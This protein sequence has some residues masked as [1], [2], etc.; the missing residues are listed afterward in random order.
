[1]KDQYVGDIGDY[2]K[3]VLLRALA[4][5][6]SVG[7]NWYLTPPDGKTDGKF[8]EY[9]TRVSDSMD[10][11]L[12]QRLKELLYSADGT[13]LN[14]NRNVAAIESSDI[15]PNALFFNETID[16]SKAID[17]KAYR[18]DWVSRSLDALGQP[19]IIFLDPDNGLEVKSVPPTRK[20][21][22]KF[23]TYDEA[24]RY[25][26]RAKVALV[27]YNHRD[28][29]PNNE[30]I[31][32]FLRFY[33]YEGTRNSFVYRLTFRKV[34]VRD[35][36][37]ITKPEFSKE[38]ADFLHTFVCPTHNKYFTIG[39]LPIPYAN[40]DAIKP[41]GVAGAVFANISSA[42]TLYG[43]DKFAIPK[44]GH[45]FAAERANHLYDVFTGKDAQ[46]VGD[47]NALNGADRMVNEVNIQT[48]FW[49]DG[50]K[51]VSDCFNENG[52][53]YYNADGSPMLIEV[54][55]DMYEAAVQ[56]MEDKIRNG[57][58]KGV[59]DPAMA[60]E[61]IKKSPFTYLQAQNIAKAGTV[62]SILYDAANGT[63]IAVGAFGIT[64][65]L[66]FAVS[67]WQGNEVKIALKSA[68][69][70]G[71]K[72]GGIAI[73]GAIIGGQLSKAGLNSALVGSSEAVVKMIGP[74]A[75]AVLVNAFRSGKSI[76]GAAAMKSAS[77]ML[78]GNVITGAASFI[79]LS[80]LD[81]ANIF[82]G[83][84]SGTQLFKNMTNTAVGI[85]GGTAGW[86]GGAA[87]GALAG[88]AIG[89][90]VPIFG[91]AAGAAVGAI[92][93]KLAGAFSGGMLAG[94]A[95]KM[96][97]DKFI[98]DDADKMVSI[99]EE[100]FGELCDEWLLS[101]VEAETIVTGLQSFLTGKILRNM[102]AS[103]DKK[104]FARSMM[105]PI[106]EVVAK[107][108]EHIALPPSD[109][110]TNALREVLEEMDIA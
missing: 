12:F 101:R 95:S 94:K 92:V 11:K 47:N 8:T 22:I 83:R 68:V 13:L 2:G 78:R 102:Y 81:I 97:L 99:I 45:G 44:G 57:Q 35:Y 110:M 20:D 19:D 91:T 73:A 4:Q 89:S 42:A 5:H 16:F 103:D 51:C 23:V 14:K 104:Q 82:R 74:K 75:S 36:I 62:E 56:A 87:G 88:G 96:L 60:K 28:R 37:F 17:R 105:E 38:V 32:R 108:R 39:E 24:Q 65:V 29:S 40:S 107:E 86:I 25:Y 69:N 54:P 84:I 31:K 33:E 76:Y 64:T 90:V 30:Y 34:S 77:K 27:I 50:S 100:V 109:E 53:R 79:V 48:K 18:K 21:G 1:M 72:I 55:K 66:T 71:L 85:A 52:F 63:I 46:I 10:S 43:E 93:G 80:S 59:T 67:V 70:E 6:Y 15:L 3:Y 58:V 98:E 61:I 106:C 9:L 41:T 49:A 26:E 7:V